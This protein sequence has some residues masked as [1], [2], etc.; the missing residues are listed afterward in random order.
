MLKETKLKEA[1]RTVDYPE[2]PVDYI[3]P[4]SLDC[5]LDKHR[6]NQTSR[7]LHAD[8]SEHIQT[9]NPLELAVGRP[10]ASENN[11]TTKSSRLLEVCS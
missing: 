6:V 5:R 2:K 1:G 7:L 10:L 3:G 4:E 8:V 9:S 11:V